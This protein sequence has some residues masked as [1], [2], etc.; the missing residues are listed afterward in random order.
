MAS[1]SQMV[2]AISTVTMVEQK[3]VNAYARALI[4][5]GTLPISKG[6]AIAHV[7]GRHVASLLLAVAL[8]PVIRTSAE[9][10]SI[11]GRLS[12]QT[13]VGR[14]KAIDLLSDLF[15]AASAGHLSDDEWDDVRITVFENRLGIDVDLPK[16]AG[17]LEFRL[18]SMEDVSELERVFVDPNP[19]FSRSASIPFSA[20]GF[21]CD[22][23]K[24]TQHG[25]S[26]KGAECVKRIE[27][28]RP[29]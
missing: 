24:A 21:L 16:G 12:C 29:T 13:N 20:L 19:F 11:Y 15:G 28:L 27:A 14:L 23:M 25:P 10:V 8:K 1:V 6:R 5:A 18:P 9:M 2:E 26:E 17:I 3:T 4:D 22:I 7:N